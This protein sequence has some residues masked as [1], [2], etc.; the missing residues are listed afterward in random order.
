MNATST[1][2]VP[3]TKKRKIAR[4]IG[5][6]LVLMAVT[7]GFAVGFAFPELSNTQFGDLNTHVSKN[8][9][10]YQWMLAG[11][12]LTLIL[13]FIVAY[14]IYAYFKDDHQS[15]SLVSGMLRFVYTLIFAVATIFLVQNLG[16]DGLTNQEIAANFQRF[17]SLWHGGLILFGVHIFLT[18]ML[19]KF[20]GR[21]PKIL[22][23]ATLIAGVGY[24]I[25]SCFKFVELNT[26]FESTLEAVLTLPMIVGEM[27]L[28]IW[29]LVR[30]GK[31]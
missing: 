28:A 21:I 15:M 4:T 14:G 10:L 5:W 23:W 7:G 26:E 27:G 31:V 2:L 1:T 3:T 11:I 17:E 12:G 16:L 8:F 6:S 18:G 29:L 25:T 9:G 30:G 19:M 22:Y 13:D 24:F 20:H